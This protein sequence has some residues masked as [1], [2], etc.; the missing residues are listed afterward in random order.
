MFKVFVLFL[1]EDFDRQSCR[2]AGV[3]VCNHVNDM[4][5]TVGVIFAIRAPF[6]VYLL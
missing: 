5:V 1:I 6:I 2:K 3:C 4:C